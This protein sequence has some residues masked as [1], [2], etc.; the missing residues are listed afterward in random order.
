[1]GESM[2]VGFIGLGGIGKPMA[3]NVARAGFELT[4]H[5]LREQPLA[6]LRGT[7]GPGRGQ[8]PRSR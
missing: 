8:R 1:M 7:R 3:V 5:D 4:V 2:K 6:E